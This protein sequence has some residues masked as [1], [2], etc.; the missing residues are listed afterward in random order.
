MRSILL[1]L[2]AIVRAD[3]ASNTL[4][5]VDTAKVNKKTESFT[6]AANTNFRACNCNMK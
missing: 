5:T 1:I 3:I 6:Y 2:A 4:Y